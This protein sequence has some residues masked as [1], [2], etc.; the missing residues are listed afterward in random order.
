MKLPLKGIIPPLIT[1]LVSD[2]ELD[3]QGLKN[4]IDHIITGGVHGVFILGT[5]GE[6]QSLSYSLRKEF[7]KEACRIVDKRIPVLVG[8]TDTSM[9]GSLDIARTASESGADAVVL[10]APYYLPITQSEMVEYLKKLVPQLPLPFMLYNMPSCTQFHMSEE[11]VKKAYELGA[12]GIKDSSGDLSYLYSLMKTFKN[13]PDFSVITGTELFIPE[14]MMFGGHGAVPGGAIL[15]PEFFTALFNASQNKN[16][17]KIT[18]LRKKLFLI[19]ENIY[20]VASEP[21][22]YIRTIKSALSI[23]GICN[24]HVA[25]PFHKLPSEGQKEMEKNLKALNMNY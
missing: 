20:N 4:L 23:M 5:T 17:E 6:A 14:T 10:S 25:M 18:E 13:S 1:P 8:I 9:E 15:F 21:S 12:I 7:I 22:K 3:S 11:T 16:L 19:E 2:N 24:D